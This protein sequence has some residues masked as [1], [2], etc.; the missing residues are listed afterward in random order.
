[1]VFDLKDWIPGEKQIHAAY[2]FSN[3]P[4]ENH[5]SSYFISAEGSTRATPTR[6]CTSAFDCHPLG[7]PAS[8]A[9]FASLTV[10]DPLLT[11]KKRNGVQRL[12]PAKVFFGFVFSGNAVQRWSA[13][14]MSK[15][16]GNLWKLEVWFAKNPS[17]SIFYR[18]QN[19]SKPAFPNVFLVS[20]PFFCQVPPKKNLLVGMV[21]L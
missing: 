12:A 13:E 21:K 16:I 9:F 10:P 8:A 11:P 18:L 14:G 6:G 7:E 15:N 1:M 20:Q 17:Y 19:R 4:Q 2:R 5:P 3:K